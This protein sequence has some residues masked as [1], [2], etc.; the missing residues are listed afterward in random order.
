LVCC[1]PGG[2]ASNV[3]AYLARADVPLSVSM[4]ALSTLLAPIATP[5]LASLLIGDRVDVDGWGLLRDTSQVVLL[6]VTFGLLLRR[7]SR[8]LARKLTPFSAPVASFT[9]VLIVAAILGA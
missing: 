9:V 8:P 4:T 7:L 2:T 3:I 1:C 5:A 6:P